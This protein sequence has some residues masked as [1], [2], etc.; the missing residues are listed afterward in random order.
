MSP[1]RRA[2]PTGS[3]PRSTRARTPAPPPPTSCSSNSRTRPRPLRRL[4]PSSVLPDVEL[5]LESPYFRFPGFVRLPGSEPDL[6]P[7]RPTGDNT[8]GGERHGVPDQGTVCGGR[9]AG[10]AG[11]VHIGDQGGRPGRHHVL[12]ELRG[13]AEVP[14]PVL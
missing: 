2:A 10:R 14:R 6:T 3:P 4:P 8:A 12:G 5:G 11:R 1:W 9:P 13:R 7:M